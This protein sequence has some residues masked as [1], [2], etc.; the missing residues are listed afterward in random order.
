V[1]ELEM[2]DVHRKI[3]ASE[4]AEAGNPAD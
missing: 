1:Q 3:A 4:A 2:A